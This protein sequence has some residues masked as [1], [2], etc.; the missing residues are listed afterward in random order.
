MIFVFVALANVDSDNEKINFF[1]HISP[2][3]AYCSHVAACVVAILAGLTD[4]LDGYLARKYHWES[5]FGRL[6]DP[7]ADKVFV[8]A[9]LIMMCE[10]GLMPGWM[11]IAI[12][13]REF[14]VTGLRLLAGAKG[15][16]ISADSWG[17]FKTLFQ[18]TIILIGGAAWINLFNVFNPPVW[19]VWYC[20]LL[21]MTLITIGSGIGYFVKHRS[22][23]SEST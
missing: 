15:Q 13:S 9:T 2:R 5:D 11:V 20:M 6:M 12:L 17:K 8:V 16:V 23:Y 21:L 10:Y 4:L 1:V 14:L 18:M 7:L 19:A 22:L 3:M